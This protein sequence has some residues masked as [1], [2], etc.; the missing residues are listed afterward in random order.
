MKPIDSYRQLL[1]VSIEQMNTSATIV[2]SLRNRGIFKVGQPVAVVDTPGLFDSTFTRSIKYNLDDHLAE[3]TILAEYQIRYDVAA[4]LASIADLWALSLQES[5]DT[6]IELLIETKPGVEQMF[7]GRLDQAGHYDA[8]N[9]NG[10]LLRFTLC[11][12]YKHVIPNNRI[13]G[14]DDVDE[15]AEYLTYPP[16]DE[17]PAAT[18]FSK[19]V[20]DPRQEVDYIDSDELADTSEI[21]LSAENTSTVIHETASFELSEMGNS[22]QSHLPASTTENDLSFPL[23]QQ[24][25]NHPTVTSANDHFLKCIGQNPL[26][27][28]KI[29]DVPAPLDEASEKQQSDWITPAQIDAYSPEQLTDRLMQLDTDLLSSLRWK[30]VQVC[31]ECFGRSLAERK[32]ETSESKHYCSACRKQVKAAYVPYY[33]DLYTANPVKAVSQHR[34]YLKTRLDDLLAQL[35]WVEMPL[36]S[37][38][39]EQPLSPYMS[40]LLTNSY[41]ED[42]LAIAER[43]ADCN[44]NK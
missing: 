12:L 5:I 39:M 43:F 34:Y 19:V 2:T 18:D 1:A 31:P 11:V 8:Y 22:A 17:Y 21:N 4:L 6:L 37:S 38:L 10:M 16:V 25:E 13:P 23:N 35:K 15:P 33:L 40:G 30:S 24:N 28:F 32:K 9:F 29:A 41:H 36:N 7:Q 3:H 20:S 44:P 27:H 14:L 42:V 26:G